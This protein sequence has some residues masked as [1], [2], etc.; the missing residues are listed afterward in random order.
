MTIPGGTMGGEP[1]PAALG[2][3]RAAEERLYPVVM[4]RPDLYERAI[5]LV[6]G[7][8]DELAAH[9]DVASLVAAWADA[10]EI[11]YRV[12]SLTLQP[13]EE[14]D[15]GLVAG[16]GFSLRYREIAVDAARNDRIERVRE[17]AAAGTAWVKVD[18][19]GRLESAAVVPYTWVEMHVPTG[20]AL[21]QT[22]EADVD[23]GA[24]RF[25][26]E[27]VRLD[28]LT[29]DPAGLADDLAVEET[30]DN[31]AEWS[32]AVDTHRRDI[33]GRG[34]GAADA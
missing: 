31:R 34:I 1:R 19:I 11:V 17:A 15:A 13:L 16:A 21:R 5:R 28:P 27:I 25:R 7:V 23:T 33:E 12:S 26:L 8:A 9:G 24:A 22:I 4:L 2:E 14:L 6:R 18:E 10:A 32:A 30:F 3:W 29:G 20:L